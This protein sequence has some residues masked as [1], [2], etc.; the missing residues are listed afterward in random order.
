MMIYCGENAFQ[1]RKYLF[2]LADLRGIS[3]RH[4]DGLREPKSHAVHK[5][6]TALTQRSRGG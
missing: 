3:L 4:V 2:E 1:Q 6:L 5:T